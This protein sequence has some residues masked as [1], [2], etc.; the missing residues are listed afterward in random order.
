M[1]QKFAGVGAFAAAAQIHQVLP[2]S[3]ADAERVFS[4]MNYLH[5][6]LRNRLQEA[7]LNIAMRAYNSLHDYR[8]CD[9]DA[10]AQSTTVCSRM[11]T[12]LAL[13]NRVD[14][15]HACTELCGYVCGLARPHA[16]FVGLCS[17]CSC[18]YSGA[19]LVHV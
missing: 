11:Q 10:L 8:K 19:S 2:V 7:H 16:V 14:F 3:S 13:I 9:Y 15:R 18:V 12:D 1:P 6:E 17:N 5:D 4:A